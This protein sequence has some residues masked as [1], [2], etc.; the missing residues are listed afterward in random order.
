MITPAP[1]SGT[2]VSGRQPYYD[3]IEKVSKLAGLDRIVDNLPDK[4]N[5]ILGRFFERGY[6]LSGGQR[7][8]VALARALMREAHILV[9]DEPS[10]SLDIR[11]ER[12]FFEVLLNKHKSNQQSVIFIS[13]RFSTVRHANQIIVLKS[14]KLTE[15]GTHMELMDMKGH[16]AEMFTMHAEMYERVDHGRD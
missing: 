2:I 10:A 9:L 16:Y 4:Y 12:E 8:L 7:Q 15:K 11:T 3:Q 13:H 5:T 14:G 6:E 1:T